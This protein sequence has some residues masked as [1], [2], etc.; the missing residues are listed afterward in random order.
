[1]AAITDR[2]STAIIQCIQ[3][4]GLSP[5]PSAIL[6]RKRPLFLDGDKLPL[7]LVCVGDDEEFEPLGS[8]GTRGTLTW[9]V[10]RPVAVALAFA[11]SG[12]QGDN[13][14]LRQWR[15]AIWSAVTQFQLSR[16]GLAEANNVLPTGKAIFDAAALTGSTIDWSVITLTVETLEE[17]GI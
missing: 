9:L 3:A 17:R 1:M 2:I 5:I 4:A 16:N 10:R 14:N 6:I 7:I 8:S 13:P 11:Q 12:K 15:D